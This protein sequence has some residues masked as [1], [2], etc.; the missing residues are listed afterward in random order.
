MSNTKSGLDSGTYRLRTDFTVTSTSGSTETITVY[1]AEKTV[2][3][4][5]EILTKGVSN[6]SII[7]KAQSIC[8]GLRRQEISLAI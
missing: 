1:S 3:K 2:I 4:K 6:N 8:H 5:A 7:V